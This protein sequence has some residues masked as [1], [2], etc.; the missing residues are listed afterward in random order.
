MIASHEI[1]LKSDDVL[2]CRLAIQ[3]KI[4]CQ[5]A[6]LVVLILRMLQRSNLIRSIAPPSHAE[7]H[8]ADYVLLSPPLY[9]DAQLTIIHPSLA[10]STARPC[11]PRSLATTRSDN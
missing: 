6:Q 8:S 4:D 9:E 2:K 7:V 3:R 5:V 10:S 1:L 11:L